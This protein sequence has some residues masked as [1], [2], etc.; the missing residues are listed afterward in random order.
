MCKMNGCLVIILENNFKLK[1][2]WSSPTEMLKKYMCAMADGN[3]TFFFEFL[4]VSL[5]LRNY[6]IFSLI[7]ME[8]T[9]FFFVIN[10]IVAKGMLPEM[11]HLKTL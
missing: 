3:K 6:L 11:S 1:L 8:I 10:E 5:A 2:V 7:T 4:Q 9:N